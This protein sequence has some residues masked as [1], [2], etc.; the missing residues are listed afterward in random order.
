MRRGMGRDLDQPRKP[1]T[2]SPA[3][4][5][6]T[7]CRRPK[8][9]LRTQSALS[10][11]TCLL[12]TDLLAMVPVQWTQAALT[13]GLLTTI[14]VREEL[15]AQPIVAVTRADL[16]LTPAATHLLDLLKRAK[17]LQPQARRGAV[18]GGSPQR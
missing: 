16:P 3:L 1:R 8:P 15:A 11:M 18:P 4:S 2:S 17:V 7:S 10:L 13:G 14:S 9:V 5:G 6:R 12:H